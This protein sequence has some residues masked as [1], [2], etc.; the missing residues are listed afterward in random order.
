VVPEIKK[1]LGDR[2]TKDSPQR[3][4]IRRKTNSHLFSQAIFICSDLGVLP[5]HSH[6]FLSLLL[7]FTSWSVKI[8]IPEGL[9]VP[10]TI[11]GG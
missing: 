6:L 8:V 1:W 10:S 3:A 5:L 2:N 7:S 11:S 4:M 9:F